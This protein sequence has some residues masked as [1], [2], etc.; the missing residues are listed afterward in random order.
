MMSY[1]EKADV[2][3]RAFVDTGSVADSLRIADAVAEATPDKAPDIIARWAPR[4]DAVLTAVADHHEQTQAWI[5]EK[6]RGS[7]ERSDA[8]HV[9]CWL[10]RQIT[11]MSTPEIGWVIGMDHSTVCHAIRRVWGT[12]QLRETAQRLLEQLRS[13]NP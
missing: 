11:P 12:V 13:A 6:K 10:L 9:A 4:I 5:T 7:R 1:E 8:R 2:F 3:S